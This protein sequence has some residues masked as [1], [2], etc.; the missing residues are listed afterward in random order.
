MDEL[1]KFFEKT[2]LNKSIKN[3]ADFDSITLSK[4]TNI[5]KKK[6]GEGDNTFDKFVGVYEDEEITIPT[7]ILINI[8]ELRKKYNLNEIKVI[9][10]GEGMKTKYTL[11]PRDAKEK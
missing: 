6:F 10:S 1:D 3:I 5:H 2:E 8:K 11:I 9:K 7:G 4:L